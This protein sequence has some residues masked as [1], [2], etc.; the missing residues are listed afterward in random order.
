VCRLTIIRLGS[1][2]KRPGAESFIF[3]SCSGI[4]I[5]AVYLDLDKNQVYN[6]SNN[7]QEQ[8]DDTP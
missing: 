1:L 2:P 6:C 3:S 8:T 7:Y 5:Y 4:L